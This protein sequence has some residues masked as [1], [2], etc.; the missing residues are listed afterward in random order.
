MMPGG[1]IL[2]VD[3]CAEVRGFL[4]MTLAK[5]GYQVQT[6]SDGRRAWELLRQSRF[7]CDLVLSDVLMPAMD[8]LEL[9]R[10][11]RADSPSIKAIFLTGDPDPDLQVRARS[12]GAV[13]VLSK[14]CE[15][16]RI[17]ETLRLALAT[18]T[19][20]SPE[21][22]GTAAVHTSAKPS[23]R[24][25]AREEKHVWSGLSRTARDFDHCAAALWGEEA[26]RGR[27]RAGQGDPRV[28]TRDK[29]A[30]HR[31]PEANG[32]FRPPAHQER[33]GEGARPRVISL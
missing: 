13:A 19:P 4:A 26:A 14:P 6:A 3:D 21:E 25:T 24:R 7:A 12:L 23:V 18:P 33:Q 17:Y 30:D 1:R 15:L 9:L 27:Q 8:G 10:R 20:G 11:I 2:V 32:D 22:S 16:E 29:G 31:R 28:P 5:Q